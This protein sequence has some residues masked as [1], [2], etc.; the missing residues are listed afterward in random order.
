VRRIYDTVEGK[1]E[2]LELNLYIVG[3]SEGDESEEGETE[4]QGGEGSAEKEPVQSDSAEADTG[5]RTH[6]EEGAGTQ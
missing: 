3:E 6:A 5:E 1:D 2:R 4:E